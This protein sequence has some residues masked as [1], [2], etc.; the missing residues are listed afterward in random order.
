MK[1]LCRQMDDLTTAD[2]EE[3]LTPK[4]LAAACVAKVTAKKQKEG[5]GWPNM[6]I[7]SHIHDGS[8]WFYLFDGRRENIWRTS[9]TT[10][11][12]MKWQG[13]SKR[14]HSNWSFLRRILSKSICFP[15]YV[16]I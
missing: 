3:K 2:A 7:E 9:P 14:L 4:E 13:K 10:P 15:L 16:V 11:R 5:K 8:F 12:Q 6:Q 1:L